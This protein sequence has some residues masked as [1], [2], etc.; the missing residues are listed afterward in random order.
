LT[1][2]QLWELF[3]LLPAETA[4]V[5]DT[6]MAVQRVRAWEVAHPDLAARYPALQLLFD[7]QQRLWPQ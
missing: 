2:A 7:L 5:A 6:S 4:L 1:A 3:D